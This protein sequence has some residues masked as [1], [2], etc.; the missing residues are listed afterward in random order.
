M[1]NLK[2]PVCVRW[3]VQKTSTGIPRALHTSKPEPEQRLSFRGQLWEST[4]RR[5][6]IERQEQE[7]FAKQRGDGD[8]GRAA[9]TLFG[10]FSIIA[11]HS[12]AD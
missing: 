7:R 1:R 9:A 11:F 12:I 6:E 5:L 4:Q 3:H 2:Q 8:G 10:N